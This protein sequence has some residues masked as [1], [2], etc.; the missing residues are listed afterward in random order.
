VPLLTDPQTSGGL[1][2]DCAPV[3]ANAFVEMIK[4]AGYPA[5]SVIETAE[6][7]EA[8]MRVV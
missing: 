2:V 1:L 3:R 8:R 6:A 4:A 5:V 7:G